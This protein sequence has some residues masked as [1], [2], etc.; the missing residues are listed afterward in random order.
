MF[1]LVPDCL[2]VL[3]GIAQGLNKVGE[4]C[5]DPDLPYDVR[6]EMLHQEFSHHEESKNDIAIC[7]LLTALM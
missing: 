4:L 5:E 6:H 7:R 1:Q 3:Y 2:L